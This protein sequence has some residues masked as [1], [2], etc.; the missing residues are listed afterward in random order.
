MSSLH[1]D[2]VKLLP[3]YRMIRDCINDDVQSGLQVNTSVTTVPSEVYVNYL[4]RTPGMS[5]ETYR[6][7]CQLGRYVNVTGSTLDFM[8]GAVWRVDPTIKLP[9][10]VEY[11]EENADGEGNSLKS[12]AK[13]TVSDGIS[14]GRF[15]LLVEPP[16]QMVDDEGNSVEVTRNAQNNGMANTYI[17]PYTPESIV[18][19]DTTVING[20]K[21]LSLVKLL[22]IVSIRDNSTFQTEEEERYRFL[23]LTD[24]GYEQRIYKNVEGT[25]MVGEPVLVT[26]FDGRRLDH[27][28]FYFAGSKN[29]DPEAD[30]P[31]FFK[32]SNINVAHY[33][34]DAENRLNLKLNATG[35]MVVWGDNADAFENATLSVGGGN[36][37]YV[38]TQGGMDIKQIEANGALPAAMDADLQS[39]IQMGARLI[40]KNGSRTAEEAKLSAAQET[41]VMSNTVDNAEDA[42]TKAINEVIWFQTGSEQ[43]FDFELNRRFFVESM[44]AQDRAQW[45]SDVNMGYVALT[46]YL[47]ALRRAGIIDKTPD[48][49]MKLVEKQGDLGGVSSDS[50]TPKETTGA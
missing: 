12:L 5:D 33:N 48:D 16:M 17:K 27:I 47:E 2:Y 50:S 25:E 13:A 18:D 6:L 41:S 29:N 15:G 28:P 14:M 37:L 3:R 8:S 19:W 30:N 46:E 39:M 44:T 21:S 38:G 23:I 26:D 11:L 9:T 34:L 4:T 35:T 49:M 1:P 45:Q 24:E 42:L 22:E 31:P 10:S 7:L 32:I 40:T 20:V 36:G 43:T